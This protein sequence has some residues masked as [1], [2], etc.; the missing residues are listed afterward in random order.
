LD[1]QLT[2]TRELIEDARS[3]IRRTQAQ[4]DQQQD[5][6]ESQARRT[7]IL[8][9]VLGILLLSL[10]GTIWWEYST[11]RGQKIAI[12]NIVDIQTLAK[13]IGERMNSAQADLNNVASRLP[14]LSSRVDQI[15]ASMKTSL[16]TVRNQAQAAATQVG[17]RLRDDMN[18]S[19][20][21]VQ[22]RVAALES[23]QREASDHVSQLQEQMNGLKSEIAAARAENLAAAARIDG[24]ESAQQTTRSDLAGLDQKVA[25]G[26]N[27]L[28]ALTNRL[29]RKRFD[30]QVG[31]L[32]TGEIAPGILLVVRHIDSVKQE[33][34]GTLERG[35]DISSLPIQGQGIQKPFLFDFPG[36]SRPVE[37]VFTQVSKSRVSGYLLMP[38]PM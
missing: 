25:A 5:E 18:K 26:Q 32:R 28:N 33:I 36:E 19:I 35:P 1:N 10:A 31:N 20:N 21:L 37:L 16:Q 6:Q 38:I 17:Q 7:K 9:V 2:Q 8:T 24:L 34:D 29:D 4:L 30:F 27:E 15:Q 23:N 11:L 13:T 14:A 12:A 3:E 22:S